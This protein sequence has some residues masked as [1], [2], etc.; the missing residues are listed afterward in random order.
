MN[1]TITT[2]PTIVTPPA[3][4]LCSKTQKIDRHQ[5]GLVPTPEATATHIPVPHIAVAER[6]IEALSYR[7]ITVVREEYAVSTD[8]MKMFGVMDLSSGITGCRFAIGIRNSHD[9]TFRLSC[10]VGLR[11]FVCDNLAFQGDYTPVLAKHTKRFHLEDNLAIGVDRMQRN[12]APLKAQVTAWQSQQL[13]DDSVKLMIYEAFVV[14]DG[15]PKHLAR[16]VHDLYFEPQYED[17][18]PRTLWSLSNAFTSAFKDLDPIPQYKAT[19]KLAGFLE[20]T[21]QRGGAIVA[22]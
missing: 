6:L 3:I 12:F 2:E 13:S 21:N 1:D 10:T 19:A 17:F 4:T 9:K 18:Q 8:G 22:S 5:L 16:R 20:A 15:F 11:V 14:E 7:Q